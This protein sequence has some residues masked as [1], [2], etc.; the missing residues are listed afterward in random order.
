M[1]KIDKKFKIF[2]AVGLVAGFIGFTFHSNYINHVRNEARQAAIYAASNIQNRDVDS[3]ADRLL[4]LEE[5]V[6]NSVSQVQELIT[7]EVE[8]SRLVTLDDSWHQRFFR[9]TQDVTFF[10][11]GRYSVDLSSINAN[12]ITYNH[13]SKRI[14]LLMD[15]PLISSI[16]ILNDRTVIEY[17]DAGFFR[18]SSDIE[19]TASEYSGILEIATDLLREEMESDY[20]MG[21]AKQNTQYAIQN[22][23]SVFLAESGFGEYT[24]EIAWR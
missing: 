9:R 2:A 8:L 20:L 12:S 6:I 14:V 5:T 17:T 24:V 4:L 16:E 13:S 23:F 15:R 22:L 7:T 19:L 18:F 11:V 10:A 1:L 3:I 21:Q